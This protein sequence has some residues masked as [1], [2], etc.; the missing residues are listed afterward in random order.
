MD[1]SGGMVR[2]SCFVTADSTSNYGTPNEIP[3]QSDET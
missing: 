2:I 3:V 1:N